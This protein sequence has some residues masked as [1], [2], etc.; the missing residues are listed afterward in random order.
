VA[1]VKHAPPI[2]FQ[3][4]LVEAPVKFSVTLVLV[5]ELGGEVD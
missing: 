5:Q 3:V 4:Q 2:Q 1:A